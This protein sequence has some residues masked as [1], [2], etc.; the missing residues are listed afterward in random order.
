MTLMAEATDTIRQ[1]LRS[2]IVELAEAAIDRPE[3][4]L[5]DVVMRG[6]KGSRVIEV[7][8][9]GDEAVGISELTDISRRLAFVLE[10]EDIIRGKYHLNVSS[11]GT[12]RALKMPR[13]F[14]KHMGRKLEIR[15]GS[16]V[17]K[18]D[19]GELESIS[20]YDLTLRL[21]TGDAKSIS[22]DEIKRANVILPW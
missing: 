20:D 13:Q 7:Y 3:L 2:R 9:D 10:T 12:D 4:F 1:D 11:P 17:E 5:V 6:Q 21:K 18:V 22:I 8:V 19:A 16:E 15:Y 14:K